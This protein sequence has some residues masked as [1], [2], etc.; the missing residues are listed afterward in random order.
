[1]RPDHGF[2]EVF[3]LAANQRLPILLH[4]AAGVADLSPAFE[5]YGL[6]SGMH[7][8][9]SHAL[10]A[11]RMIQSGLLDRVPDLELILTH[12]GGILPFLIDRLDRRHAGP[13][14]HPP[15]HYLRTSVHLDDS[16]HLAVPAR[17][18]AIG[19]VGVEPVMIGT[20]WPSRPHAARLN[21]VRGEC[22]RE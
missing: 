20:D 15:A 6:A 5:D 3:S 10:V 8:M 7:A 17:S 19:R 2:D 12:L 9:V 18:L 16:R 1:Y 4:P 11:A 22:L 14:R 21:A 13:T